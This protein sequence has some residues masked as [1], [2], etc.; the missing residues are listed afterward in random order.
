MH[1]G[2]CIDGTCSSP[3]HPALSSA[4]ILPSHSWPFPCTLPILPMPPCHVHPC[5]CITH[6]AAHS[7]M[8]SARYA[9]ML[10][11]L[12]LTKKVCLYSS[13]TLQATLYTFIFN[14]LTSCC[15]LPLLP[16]VDATMDARAVCSNTATC[17]SCHLHARAVNSRVTEPI[18]SS[19]F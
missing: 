17:L 6:A 19:M 18:Y 14:H 2:K 15:V 10:A 3:L 9:C 5:I 13:A 16:T 12:V 4:C 11:G 7:T 8:T 1:A